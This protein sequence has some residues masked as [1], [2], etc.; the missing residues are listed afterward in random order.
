MR[1]GE[2][3]REKG[4][5]SKQHKGLRAKCLL[6]KTFCVVSLELL[7]TH[8]NKYPMDIGVVG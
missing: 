6:L 8:D 4:Q 3:R 1:V 2:E 5:K 7:I